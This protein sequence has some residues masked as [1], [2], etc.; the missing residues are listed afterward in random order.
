MPS[1]RTVL[2]LLL[3]T[4]LL[5][6]SNGASFSSPLKD[7]N[8]SDPF[9][10]YV[11]GYYYL[12]T[13]TWTDVQ[14]TRATTLEGLKTGEVKTV[15]SDDNVLRCCSVWAPEFHEIDGV[16]YLY[17]TAG[18][19]DSLDYQRV[20]VLQGG[21]S[22]W[23]TYTYLDQVT[24]EWGIDG[25]VLTIDSQNYLIWSCMAN[26]IQCNCIAALN[27]PS[28]IGDTHI[29]SEPV[30]DWETVGAPVNEGAAPLYHD[31]RT[32]VAYSASYCWTANY[33]LALLEYEGG[34]PLDSASW[35]KSDGPLFVSADGNYG[36]GHNAFFTS[37]DGTEIW[38]VYHATRI[39][40]GACDSNR[41]T[42]ALRVDWDATGYPDLG[43]APALGTILDGPSGECA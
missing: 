39:A 5:G 17:Y 23:D 26:D 25:T 34:D 12:T 1:F 15:W 27:S 20:H 35:T 40:E 7:P 13:T 11:D 16:W 6:S 9:M 14:I 41:Y 43:V 33:S 4:L 19:S 21:S 22:P 3:A 36:T 2:R 38:N 32:W 24:P 28:S 8:G 31:G 30:E 10:V 18:S 37:P 29:L 42:A